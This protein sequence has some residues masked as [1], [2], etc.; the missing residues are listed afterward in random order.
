[1]YVKD[2]AGIILVYDMT[3]ADSVDG[4]R[5][6]YNM[7]QEHLNLNKVVVALVGNK[8]DNFED[9]QVNH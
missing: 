4:V 5:Q 7:V 8:C 1:M 2:A 9:I 3:Y 6:W